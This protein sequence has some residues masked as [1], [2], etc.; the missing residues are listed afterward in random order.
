[1]TVMMGD[2]LGVRWDVV[3]TR[4]LEGGR[5]TIVGELAE[6]AAY[7]RAAVLIAEAG[8]ALGV[9][10]A[11]LTEAVAAKAAGRDRVMALEDDLATKRFER[12]RIAR[13]VR[14]VEAGEMEGPAPDLEAARAAVRDVERALSEVSAEV[15]AGRARIGELQKQ[16]GRLEKLLPVLAEVEE[17]LAPALRAALASVARGG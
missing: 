1:M 10:Q 7:N 6:V 4:L 2:L 5:D 12:D 8:E 15:A 17:P 13:L 3:R 14:R 9:C 11:E 16:E